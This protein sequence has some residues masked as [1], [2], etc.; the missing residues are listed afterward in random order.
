SG[1][2]TLVGVFSG[3]QNLTGGSGANAF[4]LAGGSLSGT[5]NGGSGAPAGNSLQ[6]N[7]VANTW[8]ITGANQGK[9]T[10][11]GGTFSNI[12]SL[13]GGNSADDFIFTNNSSLSG[14]LNGGG[15]NDTLDWSAYTAARN[16]TITGLGSVDGVRGTEASIAG[17]FI[18]IT[19]VVGA[20]G[21]GGLLNT[22]TGPNINNTWNVTASNTGNL[23]AGLGFSNFQTLTGGTAADTFNLA[24]GVSGSINGGGG[25]DTANIVSSFSTPAP[26][27]VINNVANIADNADATVTAGTLA[28]SGASSIGSAGHPLLASIGALQIGASSGSAFIHSGNVDLQGINLGSGGLTLSST[29]AITDLTGQTVTAGAADFDAVSGIGTTAAPL[30]TAS[31]NLSAGVS[32]AGDIQ[33]QNAGATALSTVSA[34]NGNIQITASGAMAVGGPVSGSGEV[35]LATTGGDLTVGNSVT[36]GGNVNL[37]AAGTLNL[38]STIG[39]SAGDLSLT[40]GTGVTGDNAAV[41]NGNAVNVVASS[42]NIN[43]VGASSGAA[44]GTVLTALGAITLQGYTTTA[45]GL[46]INNGGTFAVT[47]P[48]VLG[49]ALDQLGAGPVQLNSSI[50]SNGD[51][52]QFASTVAAG[53]GSVSTQG[54]DIEFAQTIT[55]S[56]SASSLTLN[57]GAGTIGLS[58]VSGVG[59]LVLQTS[60]ALLF[61]NNI[62]VNSLTASGVTGAIVV[63]APT[64]SVVTTNGNVDFSLASGINGASA[65]GESLA[66]NSGS[67]DVLLPAVGQSIP[68]ADLSVSAAA[69]HLLDVTTTSAETFAGNVLLAGNLTSSANGGVTITG[70]LALQS[71]AT[72]QAAG[73]STI[74]ISGTINGAQPLALATPTGNI[75]LGGVIGASTPLTALSLNA[76]TASFG[77]VTTS[78]TQNYQVGH[79]SFAGSLTSLDGAIDFGGFAGVTGGSR[80]QADAIG[81]NGGADSVQGS[82]ALTLVPETP[83][84]AVSLGPGNGLSL[85][86]AALDGYDGALY[87][88]TGP[89]SGFP[90]VIQIPVAAG[91]VTVNGN[92]TLGD[93]G[94]L[95]LAG[96]GN[97]VIEAGTLSADSITLIAGSQNSVLRNPATQAS[98][99]HANQV[100]LVSGAQIGQPGQELNIQT[101][102]S[103]PQVQ[104]A[105]GAVQSYLLPPTLPAVIGPAATIA[106]AI[107]A[108]LGLFIQ[109]NS[110]VTSIGQQIVA[111]AQSG[112][113]LESGFV[114][115]S[116]FQN[117]SLYD[118]S[119]LGITLPFDQCQQPHNQLC[120]QQP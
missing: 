99:L 48:V 80:I 92:L 65:G 31:A 57:S 23:D 11:L 38:N 103:T 59:S 39:S 86:S 49:G 83:G 96:M 53:A 47:G 33:V 110:Q 46:V 61:G 84:Y 58:S 97:L 6:G 107:A 104:I 41:L 20:N 26:V 3:I 106:N 32:G 25:S 5:I 36:A 42:G 93:Q 7:N 51:N 91:N 40:G 45:G 81:F 21:A 63:A 27:L 114:D 68:L 62:A 34:V 108:Q 2:G 50:S 1:A 76:A 82:A 43:F 94:T 102:G 72:V 67:N 66:V 54:G 12:G 87:I 30:L 52:V 10:G 15:G 28:I 118:I 64:V 29:G 8:N 95:T 116:L 35:A 109:A 13:V 55:G 60:G 89:G 14:S 74:S 98:L 70:N 85:N 90:D 73:G 79:A 78:G 88:G 117:I 119:G 101:S 113:L 71:A 9:L 69:I 18:N 44:N 105:T 111:L 4:V 56:G 112:G 100:I 120:N 115:V 22:L 24:A 75:A 16:V 17:G 37:N 19:N 77:T